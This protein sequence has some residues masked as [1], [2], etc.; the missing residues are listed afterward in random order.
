M[1]DK[2]RIR[3]E[4]KKSELWDYVNI[5]MNRMLAINSKRS[6]KDK[7]VFVRVGVRFEQMLDLFNNWNN[8]SKGSE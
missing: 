1:M 5:L 6:E 2:D 3:N 4:W 8:D 7:M